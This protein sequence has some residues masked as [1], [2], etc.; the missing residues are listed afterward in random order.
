MSNFE[1]SSGKRVT[2]K[3]VA[4]PSEH[5]YLSRKSAQ[6]LVAMVSDFG[7]VDYYVGVMKGVMLGIAPGVAIA[8]ITHQIPPQNL[9]AARYI[10]GASVN[11]FPHNTVFLGV[12]D[13][14]VGTDRR[15]IAFK[16]KKQAENQLKTQYFVGPDNGIFSAV[17]DSNAVVDAVSLTNANY[18]RSLSPSRTFHGRDI[19]AP[20]A[21]HLVNG[22]PLK[23]LGGVIA[24]ATLTR[25][26]LPSLKKIDRG[27]EG[28]VQYIDHFGN[29]ITTVPGDS[30][31]G[32]SWSVNTSQ[33]KIPGVQTYGAME[34]RTVVALVGSHGWVEIAQNQGSGAIAT[35]LTYGDFVQVVIGS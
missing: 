31:D 25:L 32:K 17:L 20:I 14:G 29:V 7:V 15:G 26:N 11:Y 10:L 18:W 13:P 21:A 35:G 16:I 22:V 12:V 1:I 4:D 9:D 27:W 19:F 5:N 30:V 33:H 28:S 2:G 3:T 23:H 6:K 34:P 24:P 8:D